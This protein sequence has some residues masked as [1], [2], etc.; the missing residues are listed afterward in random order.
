MTVVV[1]FDEPR[2]GRID[3]YPDVHV[4]LC[5]PEIDR[6]VGRCPEAAIQADAQRRLQLVGVEFD[7]PPGVDHSSFGVHVVKSIRTSRLVRGL[8]VD[9]HRFQSNRFQPCSGLDQAERL[10]EVADRSA[11]A[12]QHS[13]SGRACFSR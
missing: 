12:D 4:A 3:G 7:Q 11:P 8:G 1:P 2:Q 9:R 6:V 5:S 13:Q 10:H